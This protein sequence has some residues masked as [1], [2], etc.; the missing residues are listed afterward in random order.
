MTKIQLVQNKILTIRGIRIMLDR[1]LAELYKVTTGNLNKAVKR[2][3]DRF[4]EDF[5]FQLNVEEYDSL[6]FQF[7]IL[8]QGQHSKYC[9]YA[10][11]EHGVVM[12]SSILNGKVAIE[13]NILIIRAFIEMRQTALVYPEYELIVEKVKRI[14]AEMKANN[15]TNLAENYLQS[16]KLLQLSREVKS[17]N[18]RLE[19]F[20]DI[21][22]QFHNAH[23]IIRRPQED[24]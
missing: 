6:R 18:Q 11:T 2:N 8:K 24:S 22:D 21:L 10:F 5:M 14:E 4:P 1:D 13:I 19:G 7:G 3:L 20:S 23:I 15:M 17:L 9:P 12:L 16:D